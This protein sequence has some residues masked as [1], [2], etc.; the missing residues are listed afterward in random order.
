MA[1]PKFLLPDM[2]LATENDFRTDEHSLK[3]NV[4]Y[5]EFMIGSRKWELNV[6]DK[7]TDRDWL[8]IKIL[9]NFILI[10]QIPKLWNQLKINLK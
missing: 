5:H 2:R 7:T 3:L 4:E 9:N 1:N 6:T 8:K 10:H